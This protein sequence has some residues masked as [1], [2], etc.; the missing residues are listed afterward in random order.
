MSVEQIHHVSIPMNHNVDPKEDAWIAEVSDVCTA[1]CQSIDPGETL[2]EGHVSFVLHTAADFLWFETEGS[3]DWSRLDVGSYLRALADSPWPNV[4]LH[5]TAVHVLSVF[6]CW[7][8]ENNRIPR[9]DAERK[10]KQL[11]R[12]CR[13]GGWRAATHAE[14]SSAVN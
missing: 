14:G 11:M 8:A 6:Y 13:T 9:S 5:E 2:P 10:V 4:G 3:P 12:Q 1:F 7:L